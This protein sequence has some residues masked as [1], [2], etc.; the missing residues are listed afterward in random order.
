MIAR[1]SL[2]LTRL[3]LVLGSPAVLAQIVT[4]GT[5]GPATSLSGPEM[6][7]GAELG[8]T[9]GGNLFHSFQRFDIPTGQRATFTGP[10]QIQNVIG[11]VTGGQTSHIDGTLR[12]TVGQAD[13]YL[14][15][16]SG[17]VM[18]P[19][20]KVDVP[21]AFHV[22]TADEVRFSDGSRYSATDPAASSLTLAAPESFGFLSPQP[23][24]LSIEGSQLELK[25]G[26]TATLTAGDVRIAGTDGRRAT[27]R[28]SGG[29]IRVEAVG[30]QGGQVPVSQKM[31]TLGGGRLTVQQAGIDVSNAGTAIPHIA[32]AS[33]DLRADQISTAD[34]LIAADHWGDQDS[35]GHIRL[36][37]NRIE[38]LNSDVR[39][40]VYGAGQGSDI[41]VST[42]DLIIDALTAVDGRSKLG[43]RVMAG[44]SGMAGDISINAARIRLTNGGQIQS[45]VMEGGIGHGGRLQIQATDSILIDGS[46]AADFWSGLYTTTRSSSDA[47]AGSIV[48]DAPTAKLGIANG[49][50]LQSGT[51]GAGAAGDIRI[52]VQG[53]ELMNEATID[54]RTFGNG[55]AGAVQ[56]DATEVVTFD[57]SHIWADANDGLGRAGPITISAPEIALNEAGLDAHTQGAGAAG[58]IRLL[59]SVSVRLTNQSSIN[60]YSGFSETLARL[61]EAGHVR[62]ETGTLSLTDSS[63]IYV[64]SGN[65][66]NAGSIEVFANRIHADNRVDAAG[67]FD[68]RSVFSAGN[69][70]ADWL[71]LERDLSVT[72]EGR[73][74][75]ILLDA[76]EIILNHDS[77]IALNTYA[78]DGG[79]LTIQADRLS[80]LNGSDIFNATTGPGR[81]S[82]VDINVTGTFLIEGGQPN[83]Q[84]GYTLSGGITTSPVTL[85]IL[86]RPPA[87]GAAGK[88]DIAA[89]TLI[90]GQDSQILSDSMSNAPAGPI[91]I[92]VGTLEVRDGGEI[93]SGSSSEGAAAPIVIQSSQ[94]VHVH[95]VHPVFRLQG[96]NIGADSGFSESG[97]A[98]G[99]V[100]ISAPRVL[101][102]QGGE[103]TSDT[104]GKGVGGLID[105]RDVTD[106]TLRSG[107]RISSSTTG[108]GQA[109]KIHIEAESVLLDGKD[110]NT[111]LATGTGLFSETSLD[112]TGNAGAIDL[113]VQNAIQLQ[114]GGEISTTTNSLGDGG[115]VTIRANGLVIDDAG[116]ASEA[117]PIATGQVGDI[118]IQVATLS[119]LNGGDI[120]IGARQ[121]LPAERVA[122]GAA[123]H[124]IAVDAGTL[125]L[126]GGSIT[127]ESA[128]ANAGSI[129]IDGDRLWLTDSLITT[130]VTGQTGHGGNIT[131]TPNYLILDGGFIQANTAAQGARGGDILIDTRALIAR[132]GQ[133]DIGGA[134]RQ[135]FITGNGRNIIQ[136]AAEGGEQGTISVTS[137]D[138]DLTAA[139][140]PLASP[141]SDPD[142]LF[143]NLC[144]TVNAS[145]ASSLVERG[146]GGLPPVLAA[147]ASISFTPE[148]LDRLH[149]SSP[150]ALE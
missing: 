23:A 38:I 11:R 80:L 93:S 18:G 149:T 29:E 86:D 134:T 46:N 50:T 72:E 136:A 135:T 28:V 17:V 107:G 1:W 66:A 43:T 16:P 110:T 91:S 114:S 45:T 47:A 113:S 90:V 145:E 109:G 92:S 75:R 27:L 148:R 116:I 87:M 97:G 120:S 137:P 21:A 48:I 118:A 100:R 129:T 73:S 63:D 60:A 37:A 79:S 125:R 40:Y 44:A 8:S 14:I 104:Y 62:I 2:F 7:I 117:T 150:G 133:L 9:R 77:D 146:H 64:S 12:S 89:D 65:L 36:N 22:S 76:S 42:D 52:A 103:I 41:H 130:S 84:Y 53:L 25:P 142:E 141:F 31:A 61:G 88:I 35:D 55:N 127:T 94:A 83:I 34:S 101:V 123:S 58:E 111:Y 99:E 108:S 26:K 119:L 106:L 74:G 139:L 71:L 138:L 105:L 10:D 24:S 57:G 30:S 144:R 20:A 32:E 112:A 78:G 122:D 140:T 81:G 124:Q 147:P 143:T 98:S 132:E 3:S 5:V 85:E 51:L 96:S 69:I 59:A 102:E 67:A 121:Q 54:T 49:A 131:L 82:D 15:N 56:I 70:F 95:G 68:G 6:T 128:Q 115:D 13:V 39:A 4:D 126:D 33:I 19:N